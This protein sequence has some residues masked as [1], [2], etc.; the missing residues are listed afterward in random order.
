MFRFDVFGRTV[1]IIRKD[2]R[3]EAMYLGLDGKHRPAPGIIIPPSVPASGLGRFLA[4]LFHE[5]ARPERPD[6]LPLEPEEG[7]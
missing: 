2:D 7:A 3:W 4:D 5:S 6:V 1:G